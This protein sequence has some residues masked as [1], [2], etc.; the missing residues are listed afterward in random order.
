MVGRSGALTLLPFLSA[1]KAETGNILQMRTQWN[2]TTAGPKTQINAL[3]LIAAAATV[4][5]DYLSSAGVNIAVKSATDQIAVPAATA[6]GAA[7]NT[8]RN[9]EIVQQNTNAAVSARASVLALAG[10]LTGAVALVLY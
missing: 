1:A 3:C 10:L 4:N 8:D 9:Q 7:G 2:E 6:T 5:A